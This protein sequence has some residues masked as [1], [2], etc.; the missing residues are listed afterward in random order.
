MRCCKANH[1]EVGKHHTKR[2]SED[3]PGFENKDIHHK[4]PRTRVLVTAQ[5]EHT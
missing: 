1:Q 2:E 5:K 3:H 4:K